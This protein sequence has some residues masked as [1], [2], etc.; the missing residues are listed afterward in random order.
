[1]QIP[2]EFEPRSYQRRW[3]EAFDNGAKRL[4]VI[5]HR[6]SGKDKLFWNLTIREMCRRVGNYLYCLPAYAQARKVVWEGITVAADGSSI[7]FLD[8]IPKEIIYAKNETDMLIT[9]RHPERPAEPGSTVQLVGLDR[10]I[11]YLMGSN[12]IGIVLSE[13]AL[14][15]MSAW[16]LVSPILR[17]NRGWAA[18]CT[19]PRGRNHAHQMYESARKEQAHA[20]AEGVPSEYYAELLTIN[21]TVRDAPGED[22][23]PVVAEADLDGERRQGMPEALIQQEYYCSFQGHL[24]GA[25]YSSLIREAEKEGRVG[26]VPYDP[27]LS[28]D[29]YWDLG[30]SDSSVVI[31]VQNLAGKELRIIDFYEAS[32]EGLNHYVKVLQNKPYTYG[33]HYGPH[34][35]KVRELSSGKSRLEHARRLGINFKVAPKLPIADGIDAVR[36]LLPRCWFDEVKCERLVECLANYRKVWNEKTLEYSSTPLHDYTSHAADAFRIFATTFRE[37]REDDYPAYANSSFNIFE[38]A[39]EAEYSVF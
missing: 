7:R 30:I 14:M 19:T 15:S 27:N 5:A 22:G 3:L 10:N 4:V 31:F 18:F 37:A 34:D 8:H 1:M 20:V 24:E 23:S 17:E 16:N 2:F 35:L 39:Y 38:P 32:G 9:L 11:D 6:R 25:F 36:A 29:S 33:S 21:D 26:K 28:V 13:F 12:P